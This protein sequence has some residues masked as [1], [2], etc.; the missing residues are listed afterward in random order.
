MSL[1]DRL[2]KRFGRYALEHTTL[3]LIAGQVMVYLAQYMNEGGGGELFER[4][5]LD[6][7]KI[8]EGEVWRIVTFLFLAP[9]GQWPLLMFFFWYLFYLMG[10]T[11]EQA[12]SV[13]RYNVYCGISYL[14]TVAAAFLAEAISLGAGI[15]VSDNFYLYGSVFLAF[16]RLF[17]DF[18]LLLMFI[19]PVKVKWLALLQWLIFGWQFIRA[20]SD[21]NWFVLLTI[22]AAV[23]NYFW[24]FA[25]EIWLDVKQGHR[26]NVHRS[27]TLKAANTKIVHEC[28]VC[29]LTSQIDPKATFRYCSK[30]AG[31]CCYCSEHIRDHEHVVTDQPEK[32][33]NS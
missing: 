23:G 13:F 25:K 31:Q 9:L 17:P 32:I 15:G 3:V 19:I 22:L 1:L 2:E 33:K 4:L 6:P 12:W 8:Y 21:A 7:G 27:K 16:A 24:F 28:R 20:T 26:R 11:L 18:Q 14:L 10:T 29:G 5:S 30:C